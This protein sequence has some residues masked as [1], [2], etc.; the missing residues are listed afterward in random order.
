[1]NGNRGFTL[2]EML[3]VI[4]MIAVLIAL[5]LPAV[6]SAREAARRAQCINNLKHVGLATHN[7]HASGSGFLPS[8]CDHDEIATFEFN[9]T[10]NLSTGRTQGEGDYQDY[11][12]DCEV[13]AHLA[14]GPPGSADAFAFF[15]EL[16]F[17]C[18]GYPRGGVLLEGSYTPQ[19]PGAQG[20]FLIYVVDAGEPGANTD[21]FAFQLQ[22]GE[23]DGYFNCGVITGGNIQ[24]FGFD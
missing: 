13:D 20:A 21:F 2:I 18:P 12:F 7:Y 5:L 8:A 3:V 4:A 23:F 16:D 11:G 1:M 9:A 24:V 6:Q 15:T 22:L 14:M 17:E 10:I 19:P